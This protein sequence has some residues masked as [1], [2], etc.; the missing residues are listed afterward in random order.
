MKKY[1]YTTMA[2][3]LVTLCSCSKTETAADGFEFPEVT[4]ENGE[5]NVAIDS[6]EPAPS[7]NYKRRLE[8]F[9]MQAP[10]GK[11][12]RV[13]ANGDVVKIKYQMRQWKTGA[14]ID[15][16]GSYPV[17]VV[18]GKTPDEQAEIL[19]SLDAVILT[20]VPKFLAEAVVGAEVGECH[21]VVFSKGMVDLPDMYDSED[22]YVLVA[23][24]EDAYTTAEYKEIL[25]QR[26]AQN[27]N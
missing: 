1:L 16:S 14:V 13:V 23:H 15:E 3:G 20:T 22:G 21:Q 26:F 8:Q 25:A 2:I 17:E 12:G 24:V 18:A 7:W 6:S 9:D 27:N 10:A 5:I 19:A 11:E 4:V